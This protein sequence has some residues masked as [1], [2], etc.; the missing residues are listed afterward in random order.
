M[1][2]VILQ[3]LITLS[4]TALQA[5][6]SVNW[7][8]PA[9]KETIF[10]NGMYKKF[11]AGEIDMIDLR[12]EVA[13]T[14]DLIFEGTIIKQGYHRPNG[15]EED[16]NQLHFLHDLIEVIKVFKGDFKGKYIEIVS[17]PHDPMLNDH[18]RPFRTEGQVGGGF[19]FFTQ[20]ADSETNPI[21]KE[22]TKRAKLTF[23]MHAGSYIDTDYFGAFLGGLQFLD[24][25][26]D[27]SNKKVNYDFHSRK[28]FEEWLIK[29]TGKKVKKKKWWKFWAIN[30]ASVSRSLIPYTFEAS[31]ATLLAGNNATVT[32]TCKL[33]GM[34]TAIDWSQAKFY[35]QTAESFNPLARV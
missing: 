9:G 20:T 15:Y 24:P 30:D 21:F 34:A 4:F 11:C 8:H 17:S 7:N 14:S 2:S 10:G 1:K 19:V 32:V 23:D 29:A 18:D 26:S 35:F 13:K 12:N 28:S 22:A 33:S 5:Q 3:L 25:W 16:P 27:C 6:T 31:P